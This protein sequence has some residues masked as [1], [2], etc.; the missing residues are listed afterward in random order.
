[1]STELDHAKSAT[2][3]KS[4]RQYIPGGV[5]SPVRAFRA[6]AAA[7]CFSGVVKRLAN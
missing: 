6:W 3:F 5:N 1:M 4:A 7:R 2:L